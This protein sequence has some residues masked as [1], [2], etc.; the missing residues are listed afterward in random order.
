MNTHQPRINPGQR[1]ILRDFA[2]HRGLTRPELLAI[3]DRMLITDS[4]TDVVHRSLVRRDDDGQY[5]P[6]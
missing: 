3:A 6:S 2:A 4:L 5:W 1:L